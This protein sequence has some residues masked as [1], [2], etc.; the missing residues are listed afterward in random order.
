MNRRWALARTEAIN[1]FKA[2]VKTDYCDSPS[3]GLGGCVFA[4]AMIFVVFMG[5]PPIERKRMARPPRASGVVICSVGDPRSSDS[6]ASRIGLTHRP[7]L[8]DASP[9]RLPTPTRD[10]EAARGDGL[11]ERSCE[12]ACSPIII[13]RYNVIVGLPNEINFF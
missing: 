8:R 11:L 10:G 13:G 1:F 3:R 5:N 4:R 12:R 2:A 9:F 7:T 6:R